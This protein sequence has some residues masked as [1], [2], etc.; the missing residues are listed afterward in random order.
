MGQLFI[1]V[2]ITSESNPTTLDDVDDR[3]PDFCYDD[4]LFSD[5]FR[6]KLDADTF[7][8]AV[9]TLSKNGTLATDAT[10]P[11]SINEYEDVRNESSSGPPESR[12]LTTPPSNHP[13]NQDSDSSNS[14]DDPEPPDHSAP[15]KCRQF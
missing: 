6:D 11:T 3:D 5:Y 15:G 14:K 4:L 7:Y 12:D 2:A 10:V 1:G 13:G 9:E 8:D